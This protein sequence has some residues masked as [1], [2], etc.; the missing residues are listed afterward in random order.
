MEPRNEV[1]TNELH[2][3]RQLG[4]TFTLGVGITR[5]TKAGSRSHVT[6]LTITATLFITIVTIVTLRTD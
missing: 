6:V 3:E 5:G 2:L 1:K 4:L